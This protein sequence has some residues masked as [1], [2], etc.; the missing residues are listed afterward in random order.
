VDDTAVPWRALDTT[1]TATDTSEVAR[2]RR[3]LVVAGLA[4]AAILGVA[5]FLL[6]AT[7]GGGD[8]VTV[9]GA[10]P[11]ESP[12]DSSGA[13]PSSS[14]VLVVEVVGAVQDPGV[15]RLAAGSRVGDAV[16]AAGGYA[17]RLDAARAA[18]EL[19]LAARLNDGD[20]VRVPSRDDAPAAAGVESQPTTAGGIVHLSTATAAQL[21]TLPGIGPVTAAKI[22]ASRDKQPFAAIDD[23]RTRKLVG[24]STFDKL[25]ALVAVP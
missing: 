5:A 24:A 23:L 12:G 6:A 7:G 25:R 11:H 15:Y 8:G 22:L 4:I 21:D 18:R 3:M 9:A 17:A 20:Q 1:D 16:A 2:L 14:A 19:N 10:L 13:G